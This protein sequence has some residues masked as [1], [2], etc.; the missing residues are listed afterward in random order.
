MPAASIPNR[1]SAGLLL[2]DV[3]AHLEYV[4]PTVS[5]FETAKPDPKGLARFHK[6]LEDRLH[7]FGVRRWYIH[8]VAVG[9]YDFQKLGQD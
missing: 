7:G 8:T 9:Q 6:E 1:R 2:Q 4:S 5:K 3:K